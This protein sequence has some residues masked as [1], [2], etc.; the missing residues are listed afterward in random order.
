MVDG[1]KEDHPNWEVELNLSAESAENQQALILNG[2]PPVFFQP[3]ADFSDTQAL[4]ADALQSMEP[5]YDAPAYDE[6]HDRARDPAP[7]ARTREA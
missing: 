5:L 4:E 2:T 6:G 3:S 7:P 1:F